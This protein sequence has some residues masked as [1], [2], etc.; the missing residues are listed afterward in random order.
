MIDETEQIIADAVEAGVNTERAR[1]VAWLRGMHAATKPYD[2]VARQ[3]I[4]DAIER[5][6]HERTNP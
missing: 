1:I 2:Y 5:G 3:N 6:D 4:A